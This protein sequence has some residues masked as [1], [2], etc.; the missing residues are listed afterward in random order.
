MIPLLRRCKPILSS[1][2]FYLK[3]IHCRPCI[4]LGLQRGRRS[5]ICWHSWLD[6]LS[7]LLLAKVVNWYFCPAFSRQRITALRHLLP[8]FDT[9][10]LSNILNRCFPLLSC[11]STLY[12]LVCFMVFLDE[13]WLNYRW[14]WHC[15]PGCSIQLKEWCHHSKWVYMI[16]GLGVEQPCH[17]HDK[18]SLLLFYACHWFII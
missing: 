10:Y 3:Y 9:R 16:R 14:F 6:L 8:A 12:L 11:E 4:A 5:R 7:S 17:E 13:T 2:I 18:I 15:S 1:S